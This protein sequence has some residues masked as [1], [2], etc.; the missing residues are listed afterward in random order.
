VILATTLPTLEGGGSVELEDIFA[1]IDKGLA[2][3][4][5]GLPL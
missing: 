3:L 2:L 5:A 4:E 1:K